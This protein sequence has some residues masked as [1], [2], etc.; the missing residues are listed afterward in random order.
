MTKGCA[1]LWIRTS[2]RGY[3][4]NVCANGTVELHLLA[5]DPPSADS[6]L[7]HVSPPMNLKQVVLGLMARGSSLTVFVDGQQQANVAD[8]TIQTGKV[9]LGGFG[10]EP[11]FTVDA[12]ITG[13]RVWSAG[14]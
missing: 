7:A 12:T 4:V 1:G 2:N 5:D 6:R 13:F 10:L 8:A 9:G 3:V 14:S 11:D